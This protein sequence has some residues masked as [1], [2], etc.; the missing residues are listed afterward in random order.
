MVKFV[1]SDATGLPLKRKQVAQ[2]CISCRKRKVPK[3]NT[4][5]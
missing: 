4:E 3:D 2:A 5:I 1:E